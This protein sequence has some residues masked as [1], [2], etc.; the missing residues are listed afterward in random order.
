MWWSDVGAPAPKLS[1][2]GHSRGAVSPALR[3]APSVARRGLLGAV[4]ALALSAC[5]FKLRQ[6]PNFAFQTIYVVAPDGSPLAAELRRSMGSADNVKVLTNP[7]EQASADVVLEV[8]TRQQDKVVVAQNS[9]GQVQEF[10]LR[11]RISFRLR[12]PKGKDLI[13]ETE[14]QQQRDVSY[15]ETAALAKEAEEALLL[16]SMQSELVHQ[17]MRRLEAVR[18]I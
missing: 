5:G 14:L 9:T 1:P 10:Q 4:A 18:E 2:G 3:R 13:V 11:M 6:A 16:R 12:T 8:L 7:A 15:S 17:I